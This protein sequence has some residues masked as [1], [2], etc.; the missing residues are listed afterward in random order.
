MKPPTV[1]KK[2]LSA[3]HTFLLGAS[4]GASVVG[5]AWSIDAVNLA[6][7]SSRLHRVLV[8]LMLNT[9]SA[10]DAV[11]ERHSRR[12]ADLAEILFRRF[13][14]PARQHSTLR[15][16]ALLH[17][18]GK[19]DDRFFHILHSCEPLSPSD[20]AMIEEHPQEGADILKPLES[21]HPGLSEIIEAH[22]ECWDGQGYPNGLKGEEIPL[23]ARIISVVD[24][25][26]ALTQPRS[27]RD[28]L[29]I[30]EAMDEIRR[31]SGSRFDPMIVES[32]QDPVVHRKMAA[33]ALRGQAQERAE[34]HAHGEN[35]AA[36]ISG[37][38]SRSG[39]SAPRSGSAGT[40]GSPAGR[41]NS[42]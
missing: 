18:L 4:L 24:V 27:Y 14:V 25:F 36:V 31:G 30:D 16:A 37:S 42:R 20:R 13:R 33:I 22:H 3:L 35:S 10:G 11:T 6:R 32:L 15:I 39:P 12:V 40:D 2:S 17:D 29:P 34:A 21:I 38:R 8:D 23:G 1:E 19:I 5:I 9:L 28:P 7:R 41:S 26:D